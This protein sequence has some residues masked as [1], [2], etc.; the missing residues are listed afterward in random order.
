M[1]GQFSKDAALAWQV[2]LGVALPAKRFTLDQTAQIT[3]RSQLDNDSQISLTRATVHFTLPFLYHQ[4]AE[5][6]RWPI[7]HYEF[8]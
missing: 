8:K 6:K 3:P 4:F 7:F 2:Q 5:V 1:S